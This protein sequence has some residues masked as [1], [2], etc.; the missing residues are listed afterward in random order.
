MEAPTTNTAPPQSPPPARRRRLLR[1]LSLGLLWLCLGLG[2][3]WAVLAL[4]YDVRIP[5]LRLPLAAA[6]GLGILVV[7][8]RIA[9]PW[10]KLITLSSLALILAWWFSLRPSNDRQWQRDVAVLPWAEISGE[11]VTIHNIRNCDYRTE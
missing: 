10:K 5:W 6:Y 3:F 2:S 4:F 1:G 11:R 9:G 8:L 7:W